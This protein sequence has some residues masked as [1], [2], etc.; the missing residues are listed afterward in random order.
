[1]R[2]Q[3]RNTAEYHLRFVERYCKYRRHPGRPSL[4][5]ICRLTLQESLRLTPRILL[6]GPTKSYR[7]TTRQERCACGKSRDHVQI[8]WISTI[9][10]MPLLLF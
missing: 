1:M 9:G 7:N 6:Y 4:F 5:G 2:N 10:A 8:L 3:C